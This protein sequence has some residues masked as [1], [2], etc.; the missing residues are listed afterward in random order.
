MG[1]R[2]RAQRSNVLRSSVFCSSVLVDLPRGRQN[3]GRAVGSHRAW[4]Y[5]H[6]GGV[7]TAAPGPPEIAARYQVPEVRSTT[8]RS[9]RAQVGRPVSG[10]GTRIRRPKTSSTA[11]SPSRRRPPVATDTHAGR[12]A[13]AAAPG[14]AGAAAGRA[15]EGAAAAGRRRTCGAVP[16]VGAVAGR[17]VEEGP[18]LGIAVP[19]G[20]GVRRG[21]NG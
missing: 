18:P 11:G 2:F 5:C 14:A 16:V 8:C 9:R 20:Q 21:S 12:L 10:W 15:T 3:S 13:T 7:P 17:R 6:C 1:A 4:M 19:E